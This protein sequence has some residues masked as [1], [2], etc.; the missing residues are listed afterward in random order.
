VEALFGHIPGLKV[1]I[2]STPHDAKGLLI[3]AIHDPDP[4]IY[5]EPARAY[6]AV[7]QEVPEQAYAVEIGTARVESEGE[8]LTL[9]SYGAQMI[10]AGACGFGRGRPVGRADRSAHNLPF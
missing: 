7:R 9:V 4:V 2:P 6:R 5:L 8:E 3:A 10:E 1:V